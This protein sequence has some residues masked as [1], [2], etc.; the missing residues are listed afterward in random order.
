[1]KLNLGSGDVIV[2][3]PW[4]NVDVSRETSPDVLADVCRLPFADGSA[5]RVY[6]GHLLEHLPIYRVEKA[7][8]E[9]ARVLHGVLMI[10]GPDLDRTDDPELRA[11]MLRGERRWPG[12]EHRW[13]S[14]EARTLELV[15]HVFPKAVPIP[16]HTVRPL[17][18]PCPIASEWQFAIATIT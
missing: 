9:I 7:L 14:T 3:P 2:P 13:P 11:V 10:V 8:R 12:D 17:G 16:I 1:M 4:L 5:S 18:W 6:C 15:R